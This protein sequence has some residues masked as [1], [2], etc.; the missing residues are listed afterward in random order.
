MLTLEAQC[1]N[2]YTDGSQPGLG[3]LGQEA[4]GSLLAGPAPEQGGGAPSGAGPAGVRGCRCSC[5]ST[6]QLICILFL[7]CIGLVYRLVS[8]FYF[9][10]LT[11]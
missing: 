1:M 5:H 7:Y 11:L 10:N 8:L 9:V 6:F 3:W 2:S 4:T